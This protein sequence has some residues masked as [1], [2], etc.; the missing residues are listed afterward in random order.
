MK[1]N[2]IVKNIFGWNFDSLAP[3]SDLDQDPEVDPY[4]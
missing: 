3:H 2:I 1:K 4:W